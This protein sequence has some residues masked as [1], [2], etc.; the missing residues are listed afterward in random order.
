VFFAAAAGIIR[1]IERTG[2]DPSANAEQ[3][4]KQFFSEGLAAGEVID[5]VAL[6]GEDRPNLSVL[7]DDFLDTLGQRVPQEN[8]RKRLLE[9]LLADE[10]VIRERQN[11]MQAQ[12]FGDKL[13]NVLAAYDRRQLTTAQVIERLIELAKELREARYRHQELGL[14][15]E[16]IAFYDALAGSAEDTNADPQL[17][18]AIGTGPRFPTPRDW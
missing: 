1:K 8:L 18:K 11:P 15:A 17:A 10:I 9:K 4:V 7:S 16:E 14:S 2:V 12:L 6:A 13:H 5:V 3:A